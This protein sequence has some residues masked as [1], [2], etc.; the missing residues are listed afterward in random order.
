MRA[1]VLEMQVSELVGPDEQQHLARDTGPS[2]RAAGA[3]AE[4][5]GGASATASYNTSFAGVE[6]S[7]SWKWTLSCRS[8]PPRR[9][10]SC[11]TYRS[12]TLAGEHPSGMRPTG[13]EMRQAEPRRRACLDL[14]LH[15]ISNS[16]IFD[17][18]FSILEVRGRPHFTHSGASP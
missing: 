4:A 1:S 7:S 9:C 17:L 10:G 14:F 2:G 13:V 12:I 11:S 5:C 8:E 6:V 15:T 3:D 16:L 18:F